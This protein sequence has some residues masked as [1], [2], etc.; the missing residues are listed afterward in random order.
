M[1][2]EK[3]MQFILEQQAAFAANLIEHDNR[4][5][6]LEEHVK[7]LAT[8]VEHILAVQQ[9]HETLLIALTESQTRLTEAQARQTEVITH[10]AEKQAR[11]ED[12]INVFIRTVQGILPR[13]PKE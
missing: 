4:L 5:R 3:T 7:M 1:D 9:Q 13:L 12:A 8:T 6:L 10:L 2:V 11:N